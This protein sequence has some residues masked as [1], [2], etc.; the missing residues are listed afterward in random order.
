MPYFSTFTS[1]IFPLF[2]GFFSEFDCFSVRKIYYFS[3][4][5]RI[6]NQ[7]LLILVFFSPVFLSLSERSERT[8]EVKVRIF[9][10]NMLFIFYFWTC[11]YFMGRTIRSE[12]CNGIYLISLLSGLK[13]TLLKSGYRFQQ[14]PISS[15]FTVSRPICTAPQT[16]STTWQSKI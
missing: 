10:H 7:I 12:Y 1:Q 13:Y 5:D 4:N 8:I 11:E 6:V 15:V 3:N 16:P 14:T 2:L 9:R